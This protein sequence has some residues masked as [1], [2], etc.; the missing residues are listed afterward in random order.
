MPADKVPVGYAR[1][2]IES[3]GVLPSGDTVTAYTLRNDA[4]LSVKVMSYGGIVMSIQT[5]DR[6]GTMADIVLGY[7]DLAGYLTETPYF[8]ALLGR[9]GNRIARAAFTLD[10]TAY[11]L[12]ANN[13]P[14]ALH[15][16]VKGF[17]KVNWRVTPFDSTPEGH[18]LVLTYTSTDGE[19]GYPGELTTTVTYTLTEANEFAIDYRATTTRAT[20]VNLTQHTYFNLAG[21]G[22]GP[23]LDQ[24]VQIDADAFTAIDSTLIPTGE[25]RPVQGTPFDFTTP[26]SIGAR[27]GATDQ[28]LTFGGGYDHNFVLRRMGEGMSHAARVTDPK[29]G[30]TLDVSTTEPGMQFYTGNF[31]DG[32]ITGKQGRVYAH[33]T[34][35]CLE[36]Q[37]FPDSPNQPSF[38]STILRPGQTYTSRTVYTFGVQR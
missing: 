29:T 28:Q 1:T 33:R 20:P 34:G 6:N 10:G 24:L 8:G 22:S 2:F 37:H 26:T 14:H 36:T 4:G 23:V 17:D 19:E 9:Y 38:P 15:G 16:G 13:G 27:I 31:L 5:P 25:L 11:T 12:A 18:G 35:F 32:T 30:R 7:D 3:I 21:D